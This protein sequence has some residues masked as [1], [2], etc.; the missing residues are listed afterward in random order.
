MEADSHIRM[1][2]RKLCVSQEELA[3]S[4][5]VS[6]MTIRR[7]ETGE[8][9][10][11]ASDITKLCE[12]LGCSESELINGPSAREFRIVIDWEVREM[13]AITI[14]D[15]G[16]FIGYREND[17]CLLFSGAVPADTSVDEVVAAIRARLE[18]AMAGRNAYK[19]KRG[20]GSA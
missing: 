7:W 1:L 18:A 20:D 13:N 15:P 9:E 6:L 3:R 17:D 4:V 19:A 12:V 11:R 8:R 2:R 14:G 10:P 16:V 5:G